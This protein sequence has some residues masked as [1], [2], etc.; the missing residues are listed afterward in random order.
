MPMINGRFY[1]LYGRYSPYVSAQI[2]RVHMGEIRQQAE[3]DAS[4]LGGVLG[5]ASQNLVFGL[6]NLALQ[7][8]VKRIQA[9]VKSSAVNRVI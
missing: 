4:T 3:S 6:G 1:S 5:S 8:A 7:A 2:Q 9:S